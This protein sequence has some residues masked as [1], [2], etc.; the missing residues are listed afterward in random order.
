VT[1]AKK[2]VTARLLTKSGLEH[3]GTNECK[4]PQ[5]VCPRA[6]GEGYEKCLT[7]CQQEMHAESRAILNCIEANDD[8]RDGVMRVSH[9]HVCQDCQATMTKWRI[10]WVVMS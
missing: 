6:E 2:V 5:A 4:A 10:T 1:C 9:T 8:P 7:V 3:V